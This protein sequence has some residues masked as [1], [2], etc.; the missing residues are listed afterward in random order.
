MIVQNLFEGVFSGNEEEIFEE[1]IRTPGLLIERI[2]STG[3]STPEG[4]WYDQEQDE[5]VILIT[6]EAKLKF[7][8][9]D[10]VT[11]KSGDH[12]LIPAHFRHRVEST[13]NDPPCIW[14]AVHGQLTH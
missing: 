13:S 3:Q 2:I 7:E 9:G 8:N 5:W 6:G 14:L 11:L 10:S 12:L 1:I 4:H